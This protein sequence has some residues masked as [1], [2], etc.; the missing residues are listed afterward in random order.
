MPPSLMADLAAQRQTELLQEAETRRLRV[1]AARRHTKTRRH[2]AAVRVPSTWSQT[3]L[4]RF[5]PA[6]QPCC[7]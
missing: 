7:A 5:R 6:P 3:L 1:A 4:A 2:G